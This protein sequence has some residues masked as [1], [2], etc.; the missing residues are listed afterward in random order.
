[1]VLTYWYV[2]TAAAATEPFVL[3]PLRLFFL[4][5]LVATA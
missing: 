1:M 5:M 2:L 3:Q 4:G